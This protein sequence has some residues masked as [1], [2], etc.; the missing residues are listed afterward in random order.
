MG[1]RVLSIIPE[2]LLSVIGEAQMVGAAAAVWWAAAAKAGGD[3][4]AQ[5]Q[6][7]DQS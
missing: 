7:D 2:S 5:S 1:W 3:V 4:M 6:G